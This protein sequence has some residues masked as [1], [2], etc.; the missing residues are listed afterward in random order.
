MALKELE[1]ALKE[2]NYNDV[3]RDQKIV[4]IYNKYMEYAKIPLQKFEVRIIVLISL[5]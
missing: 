2:Q 1:R 3:V 5:G 4:Q